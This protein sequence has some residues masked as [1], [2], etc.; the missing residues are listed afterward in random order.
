MNP[1]SDETIWVE[2]AADADGVALGCAE[3]HQKRIGVVLLGCLNLPCPGWNRGSPMDSP[4]LAAQYLLDRYVEHGEAFI[5]GVFGQYAVVVADFDKQRLLL[6]SDPTGLRTLF[7][8]VESQTLYFSSNLSALAAALPNTRMNRG[9]EDFFL[10]YGFYPWAQ[11]PYA[12]FTYLTPGSLACFQRG[13]LSLSSI[14]H[15]DPWAERSKELELES[16][17][18]SEAIDALHTAFMLGTEQQLAS[19]ER[20]AVLLGGADSALTAAVLHRLGKQVETFSFYYDDETFN[21]PHTDTLSR[22]LGTRH[23]WVPIR[24]DVIAR[25]VESYSW[26]FNFPT[27]WL[28][29]VVQTE[30]LCRVM[31]EAGFK[32]VYSGDGCDGTFL[33]YPRTHVFASFLDRAGRLSPSL[34]HWATRALNFD[35]VEYAMGRPYTLLL[36]SLRSLGREMPARGYSTFRVLDENSLSRLKRSNAEATVID[37]EKILHEIAEPLAH[38]SMDR[39]AYHGKNALSPN[40]SKMSGSSDSTGIVINSPYLHS[41]MKRFALSIPDSLLRPQGTNDCY[42]G[43][44]LLFKMCEQKRLLPSEVIY[45]KKVSA[46]DAP[47]DRWYASELKNNFRSS[48]DGLPFDANSEYLEHLLRNSLADRFHRRFVSSD[49]LTSH[50]LALLVTYASFAT[51]TGKRPKP[52]REANT[53]SD[54]AAA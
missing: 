29:Y 14:A 1:P 26:K 4:D 20:A 52:P 37:N 22:F 35:M 11:T 48:L 42:N 43:K 25:G 44:Y 34:V 17:T 16:K 53:R 5:A 2:S 45:Q 3:D 49:A 39:L 51:A 36:H 12:G 32:Y 15:P 27:N 13:E 46:V 30:Y 38:L 9:L 33:G 23:H 31:K 28:N 8:R 47:V 10:C 6:A 18:E 21:Q 54:S 50:A 7:Y 24:P 40:R 41:G 19:D